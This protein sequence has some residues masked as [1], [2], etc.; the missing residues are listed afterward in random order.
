MNSNGASPLQ[1]KPS[2]LSILHQGQPGYGR[3]VTLAVEAG[4]DYRIVNAEEAE[5][6]YE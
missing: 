4:I 1:V 6:P 3:L 2:F 5:V